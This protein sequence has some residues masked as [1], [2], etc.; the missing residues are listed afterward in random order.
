MAYLVVQVKGRRPVA[1]DTSGLPA[2]P[3]GD[4]LL[5]RGDIVTVY[6]ESHTS[7]GIRV[8]KKEWI[9]NGRDP[10]DFPGSFGIIHIPDLSLVRAKRL[11]KER[12]QNDDPGLGGEVQLM[13]KWRAV[14]SEVPANVKNKLRDDGE[15]TLNIGQSKA[16][17]RHKMDE[18]TM[19][20][21]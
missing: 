15:I 7:F 9:A 2:P 3:S 20:T 17:I 1:P 14:W 4:A 13:R 8:R 5:Q 21:V 12:F 11:I 18:S 16:F 6:P 19:D 10:A